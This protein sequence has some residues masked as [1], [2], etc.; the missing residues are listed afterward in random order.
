[1][2]SLEKLRGVLFWDIN[3]KR[4]FFYVNMGRYL[5]EVVCHHHNN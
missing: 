5:G 2:I 4:V 1:M 3:C